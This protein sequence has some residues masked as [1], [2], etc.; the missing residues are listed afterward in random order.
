MFRSVRT[1][2]TLWYMGVLALV[3]V[4][5]SVGVYA[6]LARY[7]YA[8]LDYELNN[9]VGGTQ[10]SLLRELA[11]GETV[12]KAATDA[13]DE[14][15][16]P[17]QAAAIF[18]PNGSLIAE[19]TALGG[20][21]APLPTANLINGDQAALFTTSGTNSTDGRRVAVKRVG[22]SSPGKTYLIIV[23]QPL[24][25]VINGLKTIRLIFFLAICAA[26]ALAGLGGS[27]LARRS[28]A[29]VARMTERARKMSAENLERRLPI[30]NPSD[31]LGRLAATFNELLSRLDDSLSLQRRFMADASHELRTPLSVMRTAT[32]VT[33]EQPRRKES[34]YR[35]ALKV[36]DEQAR[37][38][39]RIVTDMFT[40]ARADAGQRALNRTE[41]YLDKLILECVR[42]AEMLGAGKGVTIRV[43]ELAETLYRGDEGL[44]RQLVINLLDNAVKHTPNNGEVGVSLEA[45]AAQLK[46]IVSD[47]GCGIPPE[48]QPHI[49]ERF[50]RVDKSRSRAEASELGAGAGLG[51]SI[52]KWIA[53]THNGYVK[54]QRSDHT[55]SEFIASLPASNQV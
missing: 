19:D 42:A 34:E 24:D 51:L 23:S 55:G 15:I 32:G 46:I 30:T 25:E 4:V 2:L 48:A 28:L 16:A 27:F 9:T 10:V 13:L 21:H 33:L 1:R 5:F 53:E 7:L 20:I 12:S 43:G 40:L 8:E 14:H 37:R 54:L 35:D 49:F 38:L 41:F 11:E 18:D 36:V 50:Y 45:H 3:L 44:L 47:T 39:T 22:V 31:E 17:R 29:P 6:S 52:A 26:L